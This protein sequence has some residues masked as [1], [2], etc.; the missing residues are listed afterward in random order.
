M[1]W[2]ESRPLHILRAILRKCPTCL[3][4]DCTVPLVGNELKSPGVWRMPLDL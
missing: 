2:I 3:G 1:S 4:R